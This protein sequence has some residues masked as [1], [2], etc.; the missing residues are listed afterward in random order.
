MVY[1]A[2]AMYNDVKYVKRI[3]E[4]IIVDIIKFK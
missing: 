4:V 2:N 3:K 1:E